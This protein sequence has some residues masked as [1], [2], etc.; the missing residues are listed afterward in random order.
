MSLYT[1]RKFRCAECKFI[2]EAT[3]EVLSIG[4]L[5]A[6]VQQMHASQH[7]GSAVPYPEVKLSRTKKSPDQIMGTVM[8]IG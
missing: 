3:G 8:T 4:D 2:M 1:T 6:V 7:H 5:R